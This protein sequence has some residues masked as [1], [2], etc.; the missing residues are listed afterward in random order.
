MKKAVDFIRK[1]R[2]F[3]KKNKKTKKRSRVRV[4]GVLASEQKKNRSNKVKLREECMF[5]CV[6][7]NNRERRVQAPESTHGRGV[8]GAVSQ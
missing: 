6:I 7:F 2:F 4:P 1:T 3:K 5:A 8:L